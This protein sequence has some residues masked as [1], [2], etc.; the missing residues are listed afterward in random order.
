MLFYSQ[1]LLQR[2]ITF[3]SRHSRSSK[4]RSR[5]GPYSSLSINRHDT[6]MKKCI[7]IVNTLHVKFFR[8]D[9]PEANGTVTV[10]KCNYRE[11]VTVDR[12]Q[13]GHDDCVISA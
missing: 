11:N 2:Q 5:Y 3:R 7:Q 4:V 8:L 1:R 6:D 10:K 13:S 12:V 9:A